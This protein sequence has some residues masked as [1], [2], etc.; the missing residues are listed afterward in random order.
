MDDKE[1][2]QR[3]SMKVEFGRYY[4]WLASQPEVKGEGNT[5][6]E[7]VGDMVISN[8]LSFGFVIES[9]N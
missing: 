7:A 5:R 6:K 3:V 1:E 8:S 9:Y 4:A 2:K